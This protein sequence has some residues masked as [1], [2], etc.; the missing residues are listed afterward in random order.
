VDAAEG[1]RGVGSSSI[2]IGLGVGL[3]VSF[4]SI[5]TTFEPGD[6]N[7]SGGVKVAWVIS[8]AGGSSSNTVGGGSIVSAMAKSELDTTLP[9]LLV[10]II[11]VPSL[12]PR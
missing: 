8:D 3:G 6:E 7:S 5:S 10:R 2:S 11:S 9:R 12:D 4:K 1:A